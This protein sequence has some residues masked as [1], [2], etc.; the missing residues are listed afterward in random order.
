MTEIVWDLVRDCWKEGRTARPTAAGA[1]RK[2][3]E[4]A[5]EGKTNHTSEGFPVPRSNLC[6]CGS[7]ISQYAS[8]MAV[9]CK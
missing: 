3:C 5:G 2:F 8:S 4:I 6:D 9:S 7:V 1:L